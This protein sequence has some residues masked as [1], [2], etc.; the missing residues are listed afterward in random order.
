MWKVTSSTSAVLNRLSLNAPRNCVTNSG[1]NR[2]LPRSDMD[3]CIRSYRRSYARLAD[4]GGRWNSPVRPADQDQ[5]RADHRRAHKLHRPQPFAIDD[6]ADC[7][8]DDGLDEQAKPRHDRLP[9]A[10][11]IDQQPLPD[12]L[13]SEENTSELQSPLRNSN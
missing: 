6:P 10:Q 13:R 7:A 3:A 8:G 12:D 2:R 9:M 4:W 11:R 5:R 1:R